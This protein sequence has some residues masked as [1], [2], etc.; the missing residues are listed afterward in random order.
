MVAYDIVPLLESDQPCKFL[1]ERVCPRSGSAM[2]RCAVYSIMATAPSTISDY[3]GGLA[4]RRL[5]FD[6]RA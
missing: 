3:P 2:V 6:N 4:A 1:H 5:E